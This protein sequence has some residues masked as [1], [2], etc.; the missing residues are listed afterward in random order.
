[1]AE[2]TITH[3]DNYIIL[4]IPTA[5]GGIDVATVN[6]LR[7]ALIDDSECYAF[8]EFLDIKYKDIYN[9]VFGLDITAFP[10]NT[11]R[12]PTDCAP[13]QFMSHRL[14]RTPIYLGSETNEL[15]QKDIHFFIC[16]D[17]P[18]DPLVHKGNEVRT[19]RAHDLRAWTVDNMT[20]SPVEPTQVRLLFPFNTLLAEL[21]K[22]E[23]LHAV[24][25]PEKGKG[26]TNSRFRPCNWTY[27]FVSPKEIDMRRN[28]AEQYAVDMFG[29]PETIELMVHFNGKRRP[30]DALWSAIDSLVHI[31]EQFNEHY[32]RRLPDYVEVK[33]ADP[34]LGSAEIEH[35]YVPPDELVIVDIEK[36]KTDARFERFSTHMIG[37]LISS[38]L[39]QKV[40]RLIHGYSNHIL[41][42][43]ENIKLQLNMVK[44]TLIAYKEPHP[45]RK[46]IIFV[47]QLPLSIP[48]FRE[49]LEDSE[50]HNW[51]MNQTIMDIIHDFKTLR[52]SI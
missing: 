29:N 9:H 30:K 16:G 15:L 22:G 28:I 38:R 21:R 3:D 51:L 2:T 11:V 35:I 31:L 1:M 48:E 24:L 8:P 32:Q 41:S 39:L 49:L 23:T 40:I 37:N 34:V 43:E 25:T 18:K 12:A 20:I 4:K 7:Q 10:T 36:S 33:R 47:Y 44:H 19:I 26:F 5:Q 17:H 27:R 42:K 6:S 50:P 52:H 14:S 45:I 13:L 46:Q